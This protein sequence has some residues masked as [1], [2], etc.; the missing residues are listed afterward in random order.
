[1]ALI[2]IVIAILFAYGIR[3]SIRDTQ[4]KKAFIAKAQAA[5]LGRKDINR[6]VRDK[7]TNE[8]WLELELQ[9]NPSSN[10]K[11]TNKV[12]SEKVEL[13]Q[14]TVDEAQDFIRGK[15]LNSVA[16]KIVT[17]G[18]SRF[19][20]YSF[21]DQARK[22][23]IDLP[24][25]T[26]G[27]LK[28]QLSYSKILRSANNGYTDEFGIEVEPEYELAVKI[29]KE[30]KDFVE[31]QYK[32]LREAAVKAQLDEYELLITHNREL[33]DKYI[34]TFVKLVRSTEGKPDKWG[35]VDQQKI[36]DLKR[37]CIYKI[38]RALNKEAYIKE[39]AGYS[40]WWIKQSLQYVNQD[41]LLNGPVPYWVK[42]L[43]DIDLPKA[44]KRPALAK[45][46]SSHK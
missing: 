4:A 23:K 28:N 13:P 9:L 3:V 24:T 42:R 30:L 25:S 35:D 38:F 1:M 14:L 34:T 40:D 33:V 43:Y 20:D 5:G 2:L 6:I 44:L 19:K 21:T 18:G 12:I 36:N 8:S 45:E 10:I 27:N 37:E 41:Q 7:K 29:T 15:F 11:R 22:L 16:L 46:P 26:A 32:E 39:K 17:D 31:S